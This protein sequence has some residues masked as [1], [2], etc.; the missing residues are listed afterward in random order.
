MQETHTRKKKPCSEEQLQLFNE[1]TT[2]VSE[3]QS[4]LPLA[5]ATEKQ[6]LPTQNNSA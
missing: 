1:E 6:S 4:Y 5:N 2:N 3:L